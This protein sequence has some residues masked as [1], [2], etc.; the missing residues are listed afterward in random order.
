MAV[1]PFIAVTALAIMGCAHAEL[2]QFV[3]EG[4]LKID[5]GT[6]RSAMF[7]VNCSTD[8]EG[9]AL[10]I[11]L[12]ATE[13]NTRKDF[14]YDNFEGPDAPAGG[15]ALSQVGWTTATGMTQIAR[16]AAGWYA[17]EPAQSFTFGINQLSHRRE[18]PARLLNAIRDEP[19]TL[20][21]TQTGFENARRKLVARFEI[22][23]AA[24]KRL[25]DVAAACLPQ[26]LP[27]NRNK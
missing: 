15:R 23:A 3:Q 7:R 20:V 11:E 27:P 9:G 26:N 19:G 6:E 2:R 25:H 16:P 10:A 12:V 21:W 22:D 14:D 4:T 17:P 13:A 5:M 24:V 1:R 18:E 8:P